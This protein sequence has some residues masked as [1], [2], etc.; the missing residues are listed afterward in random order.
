MMRADT[1]VGKGLP[2]S[3]NLLFD[4][5]HNNRTANACIQGIMDDWTPLFTAISR[6]DSAILGLTGFVTGVSDGGN[7]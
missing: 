4:N 1:F 2:C 5:N 6:G 7:S 3:Y